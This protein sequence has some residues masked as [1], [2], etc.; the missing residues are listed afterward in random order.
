MINTEK[1]SQNIDVL[2]DY[3]LK[4]DAL[5]DILL[6][7]KTTKRR[8]IWATDS[9]EQEGKRFAP[10]KPIAINL[11]TGKYGTLIQPRAVKSQEEQ[12]IRTRDKAEVF[13]PLSI[14]KKMN[15]ASD[16]IKRV[17]KK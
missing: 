8:I 13:T 9:Y 11:V 16:P 15:K 6:Q 17:T 2:E 1:Q 14:V 5:L 4:Q 3:L 7:D 12:L 10:H